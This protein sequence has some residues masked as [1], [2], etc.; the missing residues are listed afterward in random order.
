[1]LANISDGTFEWLQLYFAISLAFES[2]QVSGELA[3]LRF[4]QFLHKRR[5]L[6]FDTTCDDLVNTRVAFVQVVKIRAFV[7]SGIVSMA[8]RA[9]HQE[10]KAALRCVTCEVRRF[11][12]SL[13][14][15]Q[16][17]RKQNRKRRVRNDQRNPE[18]DNERTT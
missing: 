2:S 9:I 3:D 18:R 10:Q 15:G 4:A 1:M 14:T 6:A 8:M 13:C 5:H 12:R 7:T 17:A 16:N 11:R